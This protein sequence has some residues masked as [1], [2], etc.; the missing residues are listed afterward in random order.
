[1]QLVHPV[2]RKTV[3]GHGLLAFFFNTVIVAV[4]VSVVVSTSE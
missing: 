4:L 1:M 2:M 3:M